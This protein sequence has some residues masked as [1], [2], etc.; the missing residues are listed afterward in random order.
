MKTDDFFTALE[1]QLREAQPAP[2]PARS[3]RP[4]ALVG[5]VA[6]AA[7]A[8]V[9]AVGGGATRERQAAPAGASLQVTLQNS[10]GEPSV[11]RS[12]LPGLRRRGYAVRAVD[13]P[14]VANTKVMTDGDHLDDGRRLARVLELPEAIVSSGTFSGPHADVEVVLGRDF[15]GAGNGGNLQRIGL[16]EA[17]G[18][19]GL[20][21]V[22]EKRLVH[23]GLYTEGV[24]SAGFAGN[25]PRSL[26]IARTASD[27]DLLARTRAALGMP[28]APPQIATREQR[29]SLM[30]GVRVYVII[31]KD[32]RPPADI[33]PN[34]DS[35]G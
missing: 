14:L 28:V 27:A 19:P 29:R 30:Q 10:T 12:L 15:I 32:Y 18:H 7:V 1:S 9:V 2:L 21:S 24:G 33:H 6:A 16:L 3:W 11:S 8:I 31:G 34:V 35:S 4:V 25:R 20:T 5:A 13:G 23:A 22:L 26:A 17:S